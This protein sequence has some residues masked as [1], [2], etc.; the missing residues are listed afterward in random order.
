MN[1]FIT[2]T[3]SLPTAVAHTYL[4]KF[5]PSLGADVDGTRDKLILVKSGLDF[6]WFPKLLSSVVCLMSLFCHFKKFFN[7]HAY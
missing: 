5:A 3:F 6:P 2:I 7:S 4:W 1:N